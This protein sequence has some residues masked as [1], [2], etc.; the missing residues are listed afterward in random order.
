[1]T[2]TLD[3]AVRAFEPELPLAVAFSGGADSTALLVTCAEK[4]PG[5][6]VALHIHHGLQVAA[7]AFESQCIALCEQLH[8]PLRVQRVD[9]RH[10]AGQSPEDAAR[11]ARYKALSALALMEYAQVAIKSVAIAQHADDQVETLLLA[12]SRGAGLA[13]LSAMPAQWQRDGLQFYRPLLQVAGAE[14]RTWLSARDIAFVEDPTN[15]DEQFTRNRIRARLLPALQQAFPQFRDTFGRSAAHAAQAQGLLEEVA[16][17]DLQSVSSPELKLPQTKSLQLL[18]RARQANVIRYWLKLRFH[19][20]PSAA[21]LNELLDQ[22][23][24]CTTRGHRI[25]IKVGEG[26]VERRAEVLDWYNPAVLL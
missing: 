16:E 26:F 19:V 17:Q 2:Q 15:A 7:D 14:I 4:W 11:Q 12:L 23:S 13:G 8:V 6:V 3:Q 1:M 9:A 10:R 20:I 21:Q 5:Q 22:I 18:S 25:H 24:V